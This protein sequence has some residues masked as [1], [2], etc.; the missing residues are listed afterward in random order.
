MKKAL[1]GIGVAMIA[2]VA[3]ESER[4]SA[5][6]QY[7]E[8]SV[9]LSGGPS[10]DAQTKSSELSSEEAAGYN[11]CLYD[12]SDKL[13]VEDEFADFGTVPLAFGTYSVSA[14]NLTEEEASA[15]NGGFGTMRLCGSTKVTLSNE[16]PSATA[17]VDC[18]VANAAVSVVFDETLY[19]ADG[20]CRFEELTVTVTSEG[21]RSLAVTQSGTE[22][23]LKPGDAAYTVSGK[24]INTGKTVSVSNRLTLDAGDKVELTVG[25]D[26]EKGQFMSSV[27]FSVDS[28]VDEIKD[29]GEFNPYE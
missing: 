15:A 1:I 3:C 20:K 22:V 24:F 26:Q 6:P 23:W 2:V 4:M 28:A 5:L 8:I 14:E 29:T 11:I 25:A 9:A 17:V 27:S 16:A 12:S 18:K 13:L 10:V 7:G 21:G 19:D